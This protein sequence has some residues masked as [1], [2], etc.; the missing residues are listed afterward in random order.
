MEQLAE[1]F[2]KLQPSDIAKI[3]A[4]AERKMLRDRSLQSQNLQ[5]L[6][7]LPMTEDE[8]RLLSEMNPSNP[9]FMSMMAQG[10]KNPYPAR[11]T[12]PCANVQPK[13]YA[14]CDKPGKMACSACRLVS[15]CSKECQKSHWHLHKQDCLNPMRSEHWQPCWVREG[16]P[17]AFVTDGPEG[18]SLE[19]KRLSA[20]LILWGNSPA[21]DVINFAVNEKDLKKNFS[22]AFIASGDL[23]HVLRSVNNLPTNYLGNLNILVN[24]YNL[25]IV[26]RNIILLLILANVPDEMEA[27]D[28]ALH[29]W[30]S[31]FM[32]MSYR[33][34]LAMIIE[35]FFSDFANSG[36]S[37]V[38]LGQHCSLSTYI[39]IMAQAKDYFAHF[40]T[41][42]FSVGDIQDEYSRVRTA[43]SRCDFR[44]RMYS[45]LKPSHRV[46]FQEYRRFG[47]LLPFGAMNAHMNIPNTSLFTLKGEWWQ[48]DFAD[49]LEGW[50]MDCVIEDGKRHGATP[51]DIYGCLYFSLLDQLC[52][53]ARRLR[54]TKI[55]FTMLC[56]DARDIP[57]T[58]RSNDLSALGIPSS[59]RYDRIAVSNILDANYVGIEGVLT[60]WGP[61]L[62]DTKSAAIVGYLMNWTFRQRDGRATGANPHS[63]TDLTQ[64]ALEKSGI[65]PETTKK[66]TSTFKGPRDFEVLVFR[67][68]SVIDALY[69]NWRPF[70]M[71]L[72]TEN[73]EGILQKTKL[74]MRERHRIVPQV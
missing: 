46:A 57:A 35:K 14:V 6:P 52:S 17:P 43:P 45:G 20:G 8:S 36:E 29:F 62:V 27:A 53:F 3:N 37:P 19:D 15:Y 48:P 42:S 26:C 30:Y 16:R 68:M 74:K 44:D 58:I 22:L 10:L 7:P 64:R 12:L 61:F 4:D 69:E 34:R 18:Q 13:K 32:P 66:R 47:I 24:D 65:T 63:V 71:Y 25:P 1:A 5:V 72:K 54:T 40:F 39:P 31:V 55:A 50:D 49:P 73:L 41:S 56:M 23:R 70:S 2:S 33:I 67:A 21:M 51:E 11:T 28:I 60:R 59:I 9:E 38:S